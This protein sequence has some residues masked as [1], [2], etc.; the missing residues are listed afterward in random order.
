MCICTYNSIICLCLILIW[1]VAS[2]HTCLVQK[3]VLL[4]SLRTNITDIWYSNSQY[5]PILINCQHF[6][7]ILYTKPQA[8]FHHTIISFIWDQTRVL[9]R[10]YLVSGGSWFTKRCP[11]GGVYREGMSPPLWENFVSLRGLRFKWC[12]LLQFFDLAICVISFSFVDD[13]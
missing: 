8:I 11:G 4:I 7:S 1:N 5:Q 13:V 3:S 12:Y 2:T 10:A 9:V 6:R